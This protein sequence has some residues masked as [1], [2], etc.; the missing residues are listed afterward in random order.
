M[1]LIRS[2]AVVVVTQMAWAV[3]AAPQDATPPAP[4]Q[5]HPATRPFVISKET[6][7]FT[8]PVRAD[9]TIDYVE[10][11]NARLSRGVTPENNAGIP[12]LDAAEAGA[13]GQVGH[14][15]RV[16][17]KMGAPQSTLKPP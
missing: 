16:R 6:T 11:I 17:E 9:G 14:Y 15:V 13:A 7:Y 12:L 5:P 2:L 3:A 8:A 4:A 10:A 1:R